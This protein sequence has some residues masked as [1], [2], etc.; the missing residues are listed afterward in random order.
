[1]ELMV[2][3]NTPMRSPDTVL[4]HGAGICRSSTHVRTAR[5]LALLARPVL[6]PRWLLATAPA[7]RVSSFALRSFPDP[8][9]VERLSRWSPRSGT[10]PR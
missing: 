9:L 3:T 1:M 6:V 10:A 2:T 7:V 8:L 4:T 5:V